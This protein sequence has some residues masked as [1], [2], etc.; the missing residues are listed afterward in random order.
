MR[1]KIKRLIALAIGLG[2]AVFLASVCLLH[3]PTRTVTLREFVDAA[4]P[5]LRNTLLSTTYYCGNKDGFDYFVVI[6]P[7]P[8]VKDRK[9][10]V[11]ESD[12]IIHRRFGFTKERTRWVRLDAGFGTASEKPIF[13]TPRP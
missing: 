11:L 1:T 13:P 6:P 9:Y 3:N 5:D 12:A 7:Q 4:Q 8:W 10:R 2:F